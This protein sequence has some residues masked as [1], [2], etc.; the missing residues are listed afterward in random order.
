MREMISPA[1]AFI[2]SSARFDGEGDGD[3]GTGDGVVEKPVDGGGTG[4][5][6]AAETWHS[7]LPEELR[8]NESLTKF[9]SIE[10]L[11]KSF[12]E[13]GGQVDSMKEKLPQIPDD[14][15]SYA[16]DVEPDLAKANIL[17]DELVEG[18]KPI[19]H[20]LG[21]SQ[22]QFQGVLD[23]FKE[24]AVQGAK[25]MREAAAAQLSKTTEELKG[26]YGD[27]YDTHLDKAKS[28]AKNL[29]GSDL[30]QAL[31]QTGMGA[32]PSFIKF[33]FKLVDVVSEDSLVSGDHDTKPKDMTRTIG[34]TPQLDFSK[35][36]SK[37]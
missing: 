19:A 23:V 9:E 7:S 13:I 26:E 21:F 18:F 17:N 33:M 30:R 32:N 15:N 22:Q 5:S 27:K 1:A 25:A 35:S 20:K 31:A 11:A 29:G 3:G 28:L 16:Y 37:K 12:V 24:Q 10:D 2:R 36:M 14:A 4:D 34:G 8:S 6:P